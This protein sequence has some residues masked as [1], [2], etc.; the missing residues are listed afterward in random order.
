MKCGTDFEETDW[1][2]SPCPECGTKHGY[3]EGFFAHDVDSVYKKYNRLLSLCEKLYAAR[4]CNDC[5]A[6][7]EEGELACEGCVAENAYDEYKKFKE[8]SE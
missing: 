7:E 4:W 6:Y 1:S 8:E 5:S 2:N 3:D